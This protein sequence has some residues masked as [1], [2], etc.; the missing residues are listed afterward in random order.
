MINAGDDP[1]GCAVAA[2]AARTAVDEAIPAIFEQHT[3]LENQIN[4]AAQLVDGC[5]ADELE[6]QGAD[7]QRLRAAHQACRQTEDDLEDNQACQLYEQ[8]RTAHPS[9]C[10]TFPND[11]IGYREALRQA[12]DEIEVAVNQAELLGGNC[13]D[14]QEALAAQ[15]AECAAAQRNFEEAYCMRRVACEGAQACYDN[16][17]A[18]F[19][20]TEAEV[21]AALESLRSE[22]QVLKHVECLLGHADQALDQS[23]IVSADAVGA[24][25]EPA[26]TDEL[27]VELRSFVERTMCETGFMSR[28]PCWAGFLESEYSSLPQR[29]AIAAAC[30]DCPGLLQPPTEPH[31]EPEP[32]TATEPPR[33]LRPPTRPEPHSERFPILQPPTEPH[34]EPEPPTVTEPP[35]CVGLYHEEPA[36][37]HR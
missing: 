36:G 15:Q 9:Q 6:Q 5:L 12:R 17:Q 29:E 35:S 26:S 16:S 31:S 10:Y 11:E 7:V 21:Q 3:H 28:A 33:V 13:D 4:I 24:C 25:S 8:A 14:A 32:P 1:S 22:Y 34:S 30:G 19:R 27:T 18:I 23:S 2:D 20:Q 37:S